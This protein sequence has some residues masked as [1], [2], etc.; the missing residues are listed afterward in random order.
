MKA[1]VQ[2]CKGKV[3]IG[4]ESG[5]GMHAQSFDGV[6]LVVLLGWMQSD[7]GSKSLD[8]TESWILSRVLGLRIFEDRE[9]KMNLSLG[10]YAT[11]NKLASGI[12]WVSQFTLAGELD[13]GFRPSFIKAMSPVLAKKR[14][15]DFCFKIKSAPGPHTHIF[16]EFGGMMHLSFTNWGPVSILLER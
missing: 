11:E 6:G 12:L 15:D 3:S 10:D 16:G 4:I 14:Y 5:A 2:R 1:F 7:L 9:G 13:S 8:E